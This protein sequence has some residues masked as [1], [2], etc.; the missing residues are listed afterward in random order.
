V[1]RS[2]LS[3]THFEAAA[4]HPILLLNQTL[5]GVLLG[6]IALAL[7]LHGRAGRLLG[8]GRWSA[9][10][11]IGIGIALALRV[12]V[13]IYVIMVPALRPTILQL[14]PLTSELVSALHKQRVPS[15]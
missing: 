15:A 5:M 11:A 10:K 14:S 9:C 8:P 13:A 7:V 1:I 6:S 3:N 4:G 12:G 2:W